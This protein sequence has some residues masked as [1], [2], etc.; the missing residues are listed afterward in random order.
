M[1]STSPAT[2]IDQTG[3]TPPTE[4][5]SATWAGLREIIREDLSTYRAGPLHPAQHLLVVHRFGVWAH[6][7]ARSKPLSLLCRALYRAANTLYIRNVLGFELTHRTKIGRRVRFVH[8]GGVVIQPDAEIGDDAMIFHGV[9]IGRR[10]E[11][12]HSAQYHMP[13]KIGRGVQVGAGAVIVGPIRVGDGAKIGPNAVVTSDV[14]TGASVVAS[15]SRT[16]RLR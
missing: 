1:E 2:D 5:N 12:Y 11:E 15:P 14:P 9:T 13:P 7:P 3:P 6:D 4:W 10:W 16:L 8:Q